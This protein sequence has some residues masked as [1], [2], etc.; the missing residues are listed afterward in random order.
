M[1]KRTTGINKLLEVQRSP[2][3]IK[4]IP[5]GTWAGKTYDI[6]AI[7]IDKAIKD[8][9]LDMTVVAE[10]IT[11]VKAGALKD[12]KNIMRETNRWDI[13]RYNHTDRIYTFT[14]GST[15]QFTSFVDEDSAKQAGKRDWLFINE[16]NTIPQPIC[17]ALMI[18]TE[19]DIWGDYNPTA[20]FWFNTEHSGT[21]GVVT[22]RLTYRDNEALP[23]NILDELDKRREKAK[24]SVYWENWCNVYLDGKTGNLEGV[25]IPQWKPIKLPEE[26]RLLSYGMD[27]G[28]SNDPTTLIALYKYNDAYIFDE[29]IYQKGL[30]NSEISNLLKTHEVSEVIYADSAEPK[31]IAELRVY[32]HNALPV[33]KGKDSIV[34]GLNLINQNEVYV[35]DR[36]TNLINEL[37]NYIWIKDR[38][39]NKINKPIDAYNHCIDAARYAITSQLDNPHRGEYFIR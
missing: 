35:T 15:I 38:E 4:E 33:K 21:E 37:R 7:A 27:F 3:R 19:G 2:C 39:G 17:D 16:M 28:Y 11:A 14:G 6:I 24:T 36:S 1:F 22:C 13:S 20:H 9:G 34:Y 23:Q 30:L 26:A 8:K 31:S 12:F 25:C 29:V 10:T 18:R 5:G 32:G